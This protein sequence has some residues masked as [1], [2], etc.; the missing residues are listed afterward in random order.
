MDDYDE[1]AQVTINGGKLT[2]CAGGDGIDSNGDL[3]VT[4]GETFVFG[5]TS[6]GDGSLDFPGTGTITGGTVVCAGSSG[7]AQNFT[8]AEGQA[9]VLVSAS[10]S[11]G[12]AIALTAPDGTLVAEAEAK[13]SFTC[14][15]VSAPGLTVGETYTLTC[16]DATS[17]VTP[18]TNV[19]TDVERAQQ[20]AGGG[21]PGGGD[22]GVGGAPGGGTGDG[23]PAG[24]GPSA[25][26]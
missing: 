13:T 4:G 26:S 9:S 11:A 3:T 19:Y 10:G 6:D 17:E 2:V 15:L 23:G 21:M 14:V 5:P 20:G 16:G 22:M 1:T 8:T 25:S 18:D 12:N 24:R 7:M